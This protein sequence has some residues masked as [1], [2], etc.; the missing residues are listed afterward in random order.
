MLSRILVIDNGVAKVG[1]VIALIETVSSMTSPGKINPS[2]VDHSPSNPKLADTVEPEQNI[3]IIRNSSAAKKTGQPKASPVA[4]K[5]AEEAGIDINT[6]TGTGPEGRITR[7]DVEGFLSGDHQSPERTK[8][9]PQPLTG[10]RS[11]IARQMGKSSLE[12]AAVTLGIQ[13]DATH[14]VQVR[15]DLKEKRQLTASY[16]DLL[17]AIAANVIRAFPQ[18]NTHFTENAITLMEEIHIGLAV[19]TPRGLLVPVIKN[20][21]KKK[22]AEIVE[23]SKDLIARAKAG[24]L[25]PDELAGGTFTITNLGAYGIDFFTPIINQPE[26]AILGVGKITRSPVVI[27]EQIVIRSIIPLSLTFDHRVIDGAP[28]AGFLQ[29]LVQKIESVDIDSFLKG[30]V[31]YEEQ[32]PL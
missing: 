12:T 24:K 13:A 6:I 28:A 14:L 20:A 18:I 23:T 25:L 19:D 21:G 10:M 29:A 7:E 17:V 22:L 16:N 32:R 8:N 9:N 26:I 3:G 5:L 11:V 30:P 27:D 31:P 1:E 2:M 4:R 15:S